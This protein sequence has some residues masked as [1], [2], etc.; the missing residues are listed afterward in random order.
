MSHTLFRSSI[1]TALQSAKESREETTTLVGP[2]VRGYQSRTP[3]SLAS[4]GR[5]SPTEKSVNFSSTRI[6]VAPKIFIQRRPRG[7]RELIQPDSV[8][9]P[10]SR[11]RAVTQ[12]D[13]ENRP[14]GSGVSRNRRARSEEIQRQERELRNRGGVTNARIDREPKVNPTPRTLPEPRAPVQRLFPEGFTRGTMPAK[15]DPA[16]RRTL[17]RSQ[18]PGDAIRVEAEAERGG[19]NMLPGL[20]AIGIV[21]AFVVAFV[22]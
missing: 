14:G 11:R 19:A 22:F 10:V 8:G 1:I 3:F 17:Q 4:P 9:R 12:P 5:Q 2:A 15:G 16:R 18:S 7:F 6:D 20:L 13:S 21:G